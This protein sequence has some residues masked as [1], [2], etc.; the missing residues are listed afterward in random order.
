MLSLPLFL[1]VASGVFLVVNAVEQNNPQYFSQMAFKQKRE[2]MCVSC[3][4]LFFLIVSHLMPSIDK[5]A[6][7]IN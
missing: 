1:D 3:G 4:S 2:C 7:L 5:N 6:I